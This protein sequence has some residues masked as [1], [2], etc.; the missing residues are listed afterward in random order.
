MR[1]MWPCGRE[2]IKPIHS[3]STKHKKYKI[4]NTN[5]RLLC[6]PHKRKLKLWTTLTDICIATATRRHHHGTHSQT[7]SCAHEKLVHQPKTLIKTKTSLPTPMEKMGKA[8]PSFNVKT[9]YKTSSAAIE[10][11]SWTETIR[12]WNQQTTNATHAGWQKHWQRP[13]YSLYS[14]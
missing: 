9:T 2:S 6:A 3:D 1:S 8:Q 14:V 4:I 5:Q 10:S 11:N 12:L 7:M 13:C